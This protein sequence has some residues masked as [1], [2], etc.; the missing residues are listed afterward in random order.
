MRVIHVVIAAGLAAT[1]ALTA[2]AVTAQDAGRPTADSIRPHD[3]R[4][5]IP[6]D[7]PTIEPRPESDAAGD[8]SPQRPDPDTPVS[9]DQPSGAA[10]VDTAAGDAGAAGVSAGQTGS[11]PEPLGP[12]TGGL[13]E[14]AAPPRT[15]RAHWH[16]FVAF[17]I[18]WLLLFG[19]AL[20]VGRRF[21]R[22]E[23]EVRR[24]GGPGA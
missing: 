11:E 7:R 8:A 23:D 6:V 3:T 4:P 17:A 5:S 21:G 18:V 22:L 19:Y 20:S 16:V 10:P 15:L 9:S 1:I 13:P 2:A 12:Y 24:L 14:R